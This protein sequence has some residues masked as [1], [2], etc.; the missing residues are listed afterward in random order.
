[1]YDF[2]GSYWPLLLLL[3][4]IVMAVLL[5]G[6]NSFFY[7]AARVV[8]ILDILFL[9]W[10]SLELK[11]YTVENFFAKNWLTSIPLLLILIVAWKYDLVGAVGFIAAG[12]FFLIYFEWGDFPIGVVPILIGILFAVS[13]LKKQGR[14]ATTS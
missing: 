2:V 12:V 13:W 3:L 11:G 7:W 5:R 1:M 8:A 6:R 9:A 4:L 14:S 10:E